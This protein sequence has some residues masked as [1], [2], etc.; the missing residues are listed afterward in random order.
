M[1][2]ELLVMAAGAGSRFGGLKQLV[3]VGPDG[4]TLT[5]YAVF[6]ALR[7]G[8][9][10]AVFVVR[11]DTEREFHETLGRRYAKRLE[12]A[13][14]HQ[15]LDDLPA[16]FA[17]P[18]GR[19]KPWGTGHAVLSA[20]GQVTGPFIAINADDW[21][22]AEGFAKLATFLSEPPPARP[23]RWALVAF[24]LGKTLTEH[25]TV[26]R[27]VCR[28]SPDGRLIS[29]GEY[30]GLRETPEGITGTGTGGD[31]RRFTADEPV[32]LNLWGFTPALFD[33]LETTFSAFL[34]ER[35]GNLSA[36]FYL[37]AAVDAALRA[38]R[39]EVSLLPTEETWFGVTY[40]EDLLRVRAAVARRVAAGLY[41]RPLW[42]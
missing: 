3:P 41:P 40:R 4:E 5:D 7:A 28:A 10:R 14:A 12:V 38:G 16:G 9:R 27:G 2:P 21:Y 23:A 11:R 36:E 17:V 22:G 15:E 24:Q 33:E 1:T 30:T 26:A 42:G 8:I 19:T 31:V 20:K 25:G 13:Y 34:R 18:P 37:P 35:G 6:D 29:I 32:S 39:A